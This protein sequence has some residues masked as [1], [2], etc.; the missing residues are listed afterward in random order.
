MYIP[1]EKDIRNTFNASAAAIIAY[2]KYKGYDLSADLL[3][4]GLNNSVVNS[5]YTPRALLTSQ[6][7]NTPQ[8][9]SIKSLSNRSGSERFTSGDL[10][11]AI[12]KFNYSTSGSGGLRTL[13]INDRYDF[14][15][16]TS[17]PKIQGVAVNAMKIGQTL[18][19]LK[20]YTIYIT[21]PVK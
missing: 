2:F 18:G 5:R 6:I 8:Y 10:Y 3:T 7:Y 17:Y 11:Y 16:D 1:T 19:Y 20:P 14:E 9:K 12:N 13:S 15:W 4:H 21:K